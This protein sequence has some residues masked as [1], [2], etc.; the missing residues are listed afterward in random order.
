MPSI[1]SMERDVMEWE[2]YR[3]RYSGEYFWRSSVSTLHIWYGDQVCRDMGRNP[4]R[5]KSFLAEWFLP[6]GPADYSDL[7]LA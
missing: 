7:H 2:Q 1:K 6:Y 5:K 3:R 4:K